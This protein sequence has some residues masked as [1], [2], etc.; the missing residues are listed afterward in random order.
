MDHAAEYR[1]CLMEAD[2]PGIMR[3]WNHTDPHLPQPSPSEALLQLHLARAEAKSIPKKLRMYSFDLLYEQGIKKIDGEWV[4]DEPVF[5][6]E[7]DPSIKA[8]SVGIA[9]KSS[10]PEVKTRIEAAMKDA[11]LNEIAKGITEPAIHRKKMLEARAKQRF[12]M[13]MA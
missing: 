12:K 7:G 4:K 9:S 11:Y 13:R 5:L 8:L 10:Y 2:V 1:R 3:V 6:G